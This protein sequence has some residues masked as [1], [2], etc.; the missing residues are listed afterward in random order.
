MSIRREKQKKYL[1]WK[2]KSFAPS[3]GP[4]YEFYSSPYW[5]SK[6]FLFGFSQT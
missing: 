1:K 6:G 5:N 2:K 4:Q 3:W